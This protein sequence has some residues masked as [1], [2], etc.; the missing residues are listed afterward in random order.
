MNRTLAIVVFNVALKWRK[1]GQL[2]TNATNGAWGSISACQLDQYT[3]QVAFWLDSKYYMYVG[4]TNT[5]LDDHA[6]FLKLSV[7]YHR[8]SLVARAVWRQKPLQHFWQN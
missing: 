2:G 5:L 7:D 4:A 1:R 8:L 3:F 6:T